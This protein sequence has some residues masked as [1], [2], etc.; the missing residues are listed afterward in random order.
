VADCPAGSLSLYIYPCIYLKDDVNRRALG[1][2][3]EE[4]PNQ[5][6]IQLVHARALAEE[7]GVG[8]GLD[9]G[10]GRVFRVP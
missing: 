5:G 8:R 1:A 10:L 3:A 9:K 2:S 7:P 4:E 6:F